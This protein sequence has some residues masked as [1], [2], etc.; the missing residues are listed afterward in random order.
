MEEKT[1]RTVNNFMSQ[2]EVAEELQ[3]SRELVNYI[4]MNAMR[5][6]RFLLKKTKYKKEDFL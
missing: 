3:I 2:K 5:K 1:E 4:E 6:L